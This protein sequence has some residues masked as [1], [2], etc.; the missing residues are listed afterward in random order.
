MPRGKVAVPWVRSQRQASDAPEGA[1]LARTPSQPGLPGT[2]PLKQPVGGRGHLP[3]GRPGTGGRQRPLAVGTQL[4][5]GARMVGPGA[6]PG[7]QASAVPSSS[8]CR[9]PVA[10]TQVRG[11]EDSALLTALPPQHPTCRWQVR[12]GPVPAGNQET[13]LQRD[14]EAAGTQEPARQRHLH[15]LLRPPE[16]APGTGHS[17][18]EPACPRR[19]PAQAD[20]PAPC[21]RQRQKDRVRLAKRRSQALRAG[22]LTSR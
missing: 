18:T 7:T 8:T 14:P 12:P 10:D 11:Q 2:C 9:L 4:R 21:G 16:E 15:R 1:G 5:V 6:A 3:R 17:R 19:A 22:A 13:H 20:L